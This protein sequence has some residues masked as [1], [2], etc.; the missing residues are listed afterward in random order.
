[1]TKF[2]RSPSV[3]VNTHAEKSFEQKHAKIAKDF[4]LRFAECTTLHGV[5]QYPPR[6]PAYP[7]DGA[8]ACS[9]LLFKFLRFTKLPH[10]G[11]R[12]VSRASAAPTVPDLA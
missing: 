6:H 1:M 7:P 5:L 9:V 8:F 11:T 10:A 3:S 2:W 4:G 12:R